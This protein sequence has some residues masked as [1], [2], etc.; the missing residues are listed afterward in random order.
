MLQPAGLDIRAD[1][2]VACIRTMAF[3]DFDFTDAEF[4]AQVRAVP[5]VSGTPLVDLATVGSAASEGVRLIYAGSATVTAHMAA[6]RLP[7]VP[8]GM[9]GST[10]V[11]VSQLGIRINET[12]MEG[13]PFPGEYGDDKLLYWDLHITPSGGIKDKYAG[14]QFVVRAGVTQ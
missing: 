5:D 2:W 9:E 1:R 7:E 4:S 13:L 10:V 3:V 11:T 14:G 8:P 12:T 6:G